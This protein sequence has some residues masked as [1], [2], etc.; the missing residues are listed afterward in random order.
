M[1]SRGSGSGS[2]A[3]ASAEAPPLP[4]ERYKMCRIMCEKRNGWTLRTFCNGVYNAVCTPEW[5]MG[6]SA[7]R[8]VAPRIE[9]TERVL[10]DSRLCVDA[11]VASRGQSQIPEPDRMTRTFCAQFCNDP[12]SQQREWSAADVWSACKHHL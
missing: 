5:R 12:E 9:W 10:S 7:Q 3:S 4:N 1:S 11:T 6:M 2:Q 8:C